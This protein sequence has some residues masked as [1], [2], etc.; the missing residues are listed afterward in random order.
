MR[1]RRSRVV[2]AHPD[3]VWR[4]VADPYSLPRWWPRTQRVE[5]VSGVGWT[6]VL[7]SERSGRSVRVDWRL[8]SSRK[9]VRRWSQELEDSPLSRVLMQYTVEAAV[10]PADG[11]SRVTLTIEQQVRGWARFAPFLMKRASKRIADE[12]LGGLEAAV[13]A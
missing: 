13:A 9:P 12:A 2:A 8:D 10:E 5:G 6:T 3:D 11:G 7:G 4:L 1:A